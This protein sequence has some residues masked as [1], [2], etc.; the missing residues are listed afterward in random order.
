MARRCGLTPT[1]GSDF[2]GTY[3]PGIA[4]GRGAGDLCVEDELLEELRERLPAA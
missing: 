2:Q 4:I 1:G 3:R